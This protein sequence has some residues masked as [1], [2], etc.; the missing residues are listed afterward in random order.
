M[1]TTLANLYIAIDPLKVEAARVAIVKAVEGMESAYGRWIKVAEAVKAAWPTEGLADKPLITE[2]VSSSLSKAE[3]AVMADG[4]VEPFTEAVK[5]AW[6]AFHNV[7]SGDNEKALVTAKVFEAKAKAERKAA[8]SKVSQYVKR[9]FENAYPA[10]VVVTPAP[11]LTPE[12]AEA[13]EAQKV[14]T[15]AAIDKGNASNAAAQA[16]TNSK[17]AKSEADTAALKAKAAE[18]KAKMDP[19]QAEAAALAQ[20]EAEEKA[21]QA[22]VEAEKAEAA[23]AEA[24]AAKVLMVATQAEAKAKAGAVQSA[25]MVEAILKDLDALITRV[26]GYKASIK[27]GDDLEAGLLGLKTDLRIDNNL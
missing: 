18:A 16:V 4:Y 25:K 26:Q 3:I 17:I 5:A 24:E 1:T 15:Q 23:K 27:G 8:Q 22:K 9:V 2:W 21:E 7:V 6:L 11:E 14:A 19:T 12:Q 20:A 10:P 13:N